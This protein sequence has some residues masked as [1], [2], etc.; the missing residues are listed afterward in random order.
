MNFYQ[1]LEHVVQ[2][3][4][5]LLCVGLDPVMERIP[6]HL[7]DSPNPLL[8]F[9]Q[10]IIKATSSSAA[11]FKPNFA[12]FEVLGPA[13]LEILQQIIQEIPK[14]TLIIGDAK[15]GDVGHSSQMYARAVFE[16]FRCDAVTVT[17]YQGYDALQPFLEYEDRG[18]F[19]LCATSN[20]GAADFQLR[21]DLYLNVA[22]K[23]KEWNRQNCGLVVGATRPELV[24]LVREKSGPMPFLIPGVGA[25]GGD[26]KQTMEQVADGTSYPCL[27]NASR[28]ILYC[29]SEEDF[30]EKAG[31]VAKDLRQQIN[32]S[33]NTDS[34][35][36]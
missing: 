5:S 23:V 29:S 12:Y 13:G 6:Q 3:K 35:P 4:N 21:Q 8:R 7:L 15:R 36:Q 34:T 27:I 17:P 1:K 28:S 14:D 32:Y 33:R 2:N 26:L 30:A 9:L 18:T 16:T 22:E 19:V 11:A 25:Q 24:K 31:Q 20:P 10:E